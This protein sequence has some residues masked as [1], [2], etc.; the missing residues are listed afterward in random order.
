MRK[1]VTYLSSCFKRDAGY[2][3]AF[4][5]VFSGSK[6]SNGF[7]EMPETAEYRLFFFSA[8]TKNPPLPLAGLGR[9]LYGTGRL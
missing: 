3:Y 5:V 2:S 4:D 6:I 9:N 8:K 1:T 7:T